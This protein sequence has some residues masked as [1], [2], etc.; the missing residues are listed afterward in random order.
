MLKFFRD[1]RDFLKQRRRQRKLDRIVKW[2]EDMA[3][4]A[5]SDPDALVKFAEA[6]GIL[7]PATDDQKEPKK[8]E[9]LYLHRD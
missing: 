6:L 8:Y 4:E 7:K 3:G 5:P 2:Y 9:P 1:L